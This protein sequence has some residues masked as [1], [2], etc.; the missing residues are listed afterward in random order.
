[1]Y[2]VSKLEKTTTLH[3]SDL[4]AGYMQENIHFSDLSGVAVLAL[5][6]K[7]PF[8]EKLPCNSIAAVT[9]GGVPGTVA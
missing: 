1:M 7:T 5:Y 4:F 3:Y 8:S 2:Y 6:G 9:A